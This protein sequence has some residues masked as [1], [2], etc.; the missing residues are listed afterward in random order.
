VAIEGD[1]VRGPIAIVVLVICA[2]IGVG[3]ALLVVPKRMTRLLNDAF[4]IVPK[5]EGGTRW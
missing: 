4:V 2:L 3:G 5:V 1:T